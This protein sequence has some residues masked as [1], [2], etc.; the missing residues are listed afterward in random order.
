MKLLLTCEHATNAIPSQYAYLFET[1]K[2]VLETHE[3]FDPGAFDL[4]NFLE[5]LADASNYQKVG[6]LL[7]ETNR[8][9]H[10]PK[11]FSRFSKELAQPEKNSIIATYYSPYRSRVEN[12]IRDFQQDN[13]VVLHISV[14]SF[15]PVFN[16]LERNCDIGILYDP[17]IPLEKQWCEQFK[18][19]LNQKSAYKIRSNYPYL[20]KADGFTTYLR[21]RFPENYLGVE[22]E[23]NQKFVNSNLMDGRVK[24]LLFDCL[25]KS[26]K[27]AP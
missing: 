17:G 23:I 3:G 15:T 1:Q 10:H 25:E 7:V 5:T 8:S 27:K 24:K 12:M 9:L 14:H 16:S 4:F 20:G 22:I 6:R 2:E 19:L 21:K 26:I 13:H 18:A 11:L